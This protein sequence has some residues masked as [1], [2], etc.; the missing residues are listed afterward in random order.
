MGPGDH[1][2]SWAFS[3]RATCGG[4][5]ATRRRFPM[6]YAVIRVSADVQ[7]PGLAVGSLVLTR[8]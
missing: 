2:V 7:R 8:P 3:L 1:V 5:P 4:R 6:T